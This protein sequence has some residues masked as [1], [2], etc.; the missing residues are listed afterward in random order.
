MNAPDFSLVDSR[1]KAISLMQQGKLEKLYLF[2]PEFGGPDVPENTTYVPL[3]LV[4]AKTQFDSTVAK[5]VKEGTVS[6]YS[7]VPEYKGDSFIP[8]RIIIRA[9]HPERSGEVNC[10]L[11]VW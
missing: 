9:W 2:P 11:E 3:G 7:A 1:E 10:T 8:A 6:Q 5:L 4:Q